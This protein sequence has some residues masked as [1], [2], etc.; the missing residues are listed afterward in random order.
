MLAKYVNRFANDWDIYLQAVIAAYRF[1][2]HSTTQE[3]PFF[4]TYGRHPHLPI[5]YYFPQLADSGQQ[6]QAPRFQ[7][8]HAA[9][10]GPIRRCGARCG[11]TPTGATL[12][13][14]SHEPQ[15]HG[16]AREHLPREALLGPDLDA[17]GPAAA[18]FL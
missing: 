2:V 4:L 7:E 3:S 9:L 6:Q 16:H 10:V 17:A 8:A 12:P 15:A 18:A 5:D 14:Q 1:S 13:A 11:A